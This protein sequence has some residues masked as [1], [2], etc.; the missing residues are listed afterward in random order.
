M[1]HGSSSTSGFRLALDF[2]MRYSGTGT[3]LHYICPGDF[4]SVL[5]LKNRTWPALG[6]WASILSKS[7]RSR[8]RYTPTSL[9]SDRPNSLS[10]GE[11]REPHDTMMPFGSSQHTTGVLPDVQ[12]CN[13]TAA[14]GTGPHL[15]ESPCGPRTRLSMNRAQEEMYLRRGCR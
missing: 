1:H 4:A 2:L 5:C 13:E 15:I 12:H 9:I 3:I 10:T 8:R 14:E 6:S 11:A 7:G